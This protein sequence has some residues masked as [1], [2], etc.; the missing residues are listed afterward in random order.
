MVKLMCLIVQVYIGALGLNI[1]TVYQVRDAQSV[2][3]VGM[4]VTIICVLTASLA[5][6]LQ[7][8]PIL[9][10]A[11]LLNVFRLVSIVFCPLIIS[12]NCSN[13]IRL[14]SYMATKQNNNSCTT[15]KLT[16][17]PITTSL[18]HISQLAAV[19]EA[20]HN[21]VFL[22]VKLLDNDNQA[23]FKLTGI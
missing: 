4:A 11:V 7:Q 15:P 18:D 16:T 14:P 6:H 9:V 13:M 21:V 5:S 22:F 8:H 2:K 3:D 1:L 20:Q 10:S 12:I 23:A 19:S 17:P